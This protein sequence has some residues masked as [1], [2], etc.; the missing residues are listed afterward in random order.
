MDKSA[1]RQ[2]YSEVSAAGRSEA[3]SLVSVQRNDLWSPYGAESQAMSLTRAF[4]SAL[5]GTQWGLLLSKRAS[6]CVL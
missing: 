4:Q 3:Y 1:P 2:V 5:D 6:W